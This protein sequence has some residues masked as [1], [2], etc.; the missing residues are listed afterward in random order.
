[1]SDEALTLKK[2]QVEEYIK[3]HPDSIEFDVLDGPGGSVVTSV[4]GF[5]DNPVKGE[6]AR[7]MGAV[8]WHKRTPHLTIYTGNASL[9]TPGT[10]YVSVDSVEY[11][12]REMSDDK[13]P[14]SY[15]TVLWLV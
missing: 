8:E 2:Q 7:Q 13:S 5:F 11:K 12:V 15:Q 14:G 6:D 10:T 3:C 9:F 1:M 4:S